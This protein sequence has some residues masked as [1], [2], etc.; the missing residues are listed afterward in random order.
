MIVPMKIYR[1]I[2]MTTFAT[3]TLFLLNVFSW[4]FLQHFGLGD[5]FTRS[6]CRHALWPGLWWGDGAIDPSVCPN[7]LGSANNGLMTLVT[8]MFLHGS[9]LHLIGNMWFLLLFARH[10]EDALREPG[11]FLLFFVLCGIAGNLT[12]LVIDSDRVVAVMGASGAIAGVMGAYI[13]F[14]PRVR[15]LSLIPIHV[16]PIPIKSPGWLAI[17]FWFAFQVV[18]G[19]FALLGQDGD[20]AYGCHV[21]GFVAGVAFAMLYRSLRPSPVAEQKETLETKPSGRIIGLDLGTTNA[22]AAVLQGKEAKIIEV[23]AGQRTTPVFAVYS[24]D[25]PPLV[26][27]IARRRALENPRNALFGVKRLLGCEFGGQLG[28][29]T[30][31]YRLIAAPAGTGVG[32]EIEGGVVS[33]EEV[34]AEVLAMVKTTAREQLGQDVAGVVVAV[35]AHFYDRQRRAIRKA[36]AAAGLEV[37]RI[38]CEP[39]A[40]ALAYWLGNPSGTARIA[41]YDLG[42]GSFDFSIIDLHVDGNGDAVVDV[43]AS[44]SAPFLGGEDFEQRVVD[45]LSGEFERVHGVDPRTDSA[46]LSRLREAAETAKI[47][48]SSSRETEINLRYLSVDSS[49][50]PK[51]LVTK[52]TRTKLEELVGDLVEQTIRRCGATLKDAGRNVREFDDVLLLG[53]QARMPLV[54]QRVRAFFAQEARLHAQ[55]GE[56]VATGAAVQAALMSG[57]FKRLAL[58]ETTALGLG[59]ATS[60]GR[61]EPLIERNS[62]L[63]LARSRIFSAAEDDPTTITIHLLQGEHENAEENASVGRF[64]ATGLPPA[65]PGATRLEFTFEVNLDGLVSVSAKDPDTGR[66]WPVQAAWA[67]GS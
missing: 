54:K 44:S 23:S 30:V 12:E 61:M 52:L 31:P 19:L 8:S 43:V 46:T 13:V 5:D 53:G 20:I 38:I 27:E 4:I 45:Y 17:L 55:S 56:T 57:D 6:L 34:V 49:T 32:I 65:L 10:V 3:Y 40:A 42:G 62:H 39:S 11:L 16:I 35:P 21:G 47:E 9:W 22:C 37:K 24:G 7:P 64:V 25:G 67:D 14:F 2:S 41:V 33:P 28:K 59:T 1:Q 60:E 26:G 15:I 29:W 66:D 50:G 51:H 58:I 48:L 18:S 63:P 36:G